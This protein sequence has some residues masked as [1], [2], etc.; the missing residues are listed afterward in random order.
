MAEA[1]HAHHERDGKGG[2]QREVVCDE[3]LETPVRQADRV[4]QAGGRLP[5]PGRRV[6]LARRDRDRLGD[7]RRERETLAERRAEGAKRRDRIERARAVED[8]MLELERSDPWGEALLRDGR[9]RSS[10]ESS[11]SD[12]ATTGPSTQIRR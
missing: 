10:Q 3:P 2:E 12:A 6:A 1:G 8:R 4:D 7:E 9:Q 5:E 11:R